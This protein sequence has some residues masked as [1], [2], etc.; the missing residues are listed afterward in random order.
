[1]S[2]RGGGFGRYFFIRLLTGRF[3]PIY[4]SRKFGNSLILE[5]V[6]RSYTHTSLIE[7]CIDPDAEDR[8]SAQFEEIVVNAYVFNAEQFFPYARYQVFGFVC[9]SSIIV[10][11]IRPGVSSDLAVLIA[12]HGFKL[13]PLV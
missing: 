1:F 3:A 8:V 5:Q 9:G 12:S 13:Y 2:V 11:Q 7:L 10:R 6:F 4:R